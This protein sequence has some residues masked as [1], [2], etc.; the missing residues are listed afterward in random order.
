MSQPSPPPPWIPLFGGMLAVT[1]SIVSSSQADSTAINWLA[2]FF[3]L[4]TV[5]SELLAVPTLKS[6]AIYQQIGS[7]LNTAARMLCT[8]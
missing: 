1:A 5:Y 6:N 2:I 4:T 7:L 8:R 3:A